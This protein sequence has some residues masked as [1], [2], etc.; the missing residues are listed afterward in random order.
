M[1]VS[2]THGSLYLFQIFLLIRGTGNLDIT[3]T[4]DMWLMVLRVRHAQAKKRTM[5]RSDSSLNEENS[6]LIW[7]KREN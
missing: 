4:S 6:A 3:P 5:R 7:K 2:T 1:T